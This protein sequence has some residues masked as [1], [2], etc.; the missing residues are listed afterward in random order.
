[1]KR[2]RRIDRVSL[3]ALTG[4]ALMVFVALPLALSLFAIMLIAPDQHPYWLAALVIGALGAGS[5]VTFS[6]LFVGA[7][8]T[9]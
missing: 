3:A 9:L 5:L 7:I 2:L 1:M 6:A 8:K 4:I